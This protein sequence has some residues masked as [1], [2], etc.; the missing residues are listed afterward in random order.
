M[1]TIKAWADCLQTADTNRFLRLI[2]KK[3]HYFPRIIMYAFLAVTVWYVS[4]YSKALLSGSVSL[5]SAVDFALVSVL[6][7]FLTLRFGRYIG[8]KAE[9]NI[10]EIYELSYIH[11]SSADERLVGESKAKIAR[12]VMK[13]AGA[14]LAAFIIGIASSI[15]ATIMLNK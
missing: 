14:V 6:S 15:V 5:K 9:K 7:A 11:F 10:D 8:S 2:R 3:S 4:Q 12:S 13:S 1:S